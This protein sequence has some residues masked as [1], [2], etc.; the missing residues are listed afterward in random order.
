M[1][2][3]GKSSLAVSLFTLSMAPKRIWGQARTCY[4]SPEPDPGVAKRAGVN[5]SEASA[6]GKQGALGH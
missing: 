5:L 1:S 4:S 3:K 2:G 6:L